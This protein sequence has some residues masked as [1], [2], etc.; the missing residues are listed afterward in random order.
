MQFDL[1]VEI[2]A[3]SRNKH[4]TDHER[5]RVPRSPARRITRAEH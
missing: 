5:R 2:P 4:Q 1:I 3:G